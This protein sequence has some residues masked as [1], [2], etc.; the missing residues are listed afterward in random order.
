MEKIAVI[1]D[2]HF[3][4]T[5]IDRAARFSR[6]LENISTEVSS[7]YFLGDLFQVWVGIEKP[8]PD[9]IRI[10]AGTV[11]LLTLRGTRT[12]Y[13]E[14]NRDFGIG[15]LNAK[16]K[17]FSEVST[18]SMEF[19][20]GGVNFRLDHGDR[21]NKE[22]RRYRIWRFLSK[23]YIAPAG[24][25]LLPGRAALWGAKAA[26]KLLSRTNIEHKLLFPKEQC[27]LY[28][29]GQFARGRDVVV[30]GHFH[31]NVLIPAEQGRRLF[32]VLED[33]PSWGSY[34]LFDDQGKLELRQEPSAAR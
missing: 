11:A 20:F 28:A 7:I 4:E 12:V 1:A 9:H 21:I 3:K 34:L 8:M 14:G 26:E 17:I 16:A 30:V 19:S 18:G 10:V 13:I 33:W 23:N 31:Y 2:C 6:F 24:I 5:E 32:L 29:Q 22:D 27:L 25:F 15:R